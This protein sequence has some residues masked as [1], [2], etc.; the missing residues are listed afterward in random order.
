V[1]AA[2]LGR[3]AVGQQRH[4]EVAHE[5]GPHRGLHAQVRD[6]PADDQLA[7][8]EAAQQRLQ[9]GPLEGVEAHLVDHQILGP[10]AQL[11]HHIGVPETGGQ[12]G[13]TGQGGAVPD[14]RGA[15]V[16]PARPVQMPGEY[17]RDRGPAGLGDRG[18]GVA[19]GGFGAVGAH[20][21]AGERAVRMTEAILHVHDEQRPVCHV[22]TSSAGQSLFTVTGSARREYP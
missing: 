21:D 1:Q 10:A 6:H 4:R 13:D 7:D 5:R 17:H 15:L 9:R 11:V 19:D 22:A 2:G 18:G 16:G 3:A 8:V 20:A 14:Q 12:P